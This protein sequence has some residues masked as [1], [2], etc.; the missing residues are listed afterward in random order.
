MND[1]Q[2][3]SETPSR[4]CLFNLNWSHYVELLCIEDPPERSFYEIEAANE[5]WSVAELKRQKP[6]CLYER[7]ALS[8][9]KAG[10]QELTREGQL[11]TKA[12]D[13]LKEPYVLELL[14]LSQSRVTIRH[15]RCYRL[16]QGLQPRR[17][18]KATSLDKN[19]TLHFLEPVRG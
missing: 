10:V 14:G 13:I 7:L 11:A 9:D 2:K 12:E 17:T 6:S 1:L 5:G 19:A 4:K 3:I 18:S 15:Y 16:Q 8:R